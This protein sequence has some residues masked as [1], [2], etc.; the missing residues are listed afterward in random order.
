MR[1]TIVKG[2]TRYVLCLCLRTRTRVSAPELNEL[3]AANGGR[4]RLL[5]LSEVTETGCWIVM[6]PELL[7]QRGHG[8][9]TN[10]ETKRRFTLAQSSRLLFLALF[11]KN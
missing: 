7:E 8:K 2:R 10:G 3:A 11:L 6:T 1:K 4:K 5:Q 9:H